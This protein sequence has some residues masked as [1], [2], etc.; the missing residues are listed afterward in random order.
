LFTFSKLHANAGAKLRAEISLLPSSLVTFDQGG[1]TRSNHV[2]DSMPNHAITE[3][4]DAEN[5]KPVTAATKVLDAANNEPVSA[6]VANNEPARAS[7]SGVQEI[8]ATS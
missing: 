5:N 2:L 6:A 8:E 4:F 1:V 7:V 3:I